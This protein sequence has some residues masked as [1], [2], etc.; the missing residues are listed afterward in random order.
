VAD[1]LRPLGIELTSLPVSPQRLWDVIKSAS[2][3]REQNR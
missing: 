2:N 1:A 3:R